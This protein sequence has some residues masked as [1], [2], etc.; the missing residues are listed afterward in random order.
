MRLFM[1]LKKNYEQR[2]F[3]L[4]SPNYLVLKML[5]LRMS[6]ST[7]STLIAHLDLYG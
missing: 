6:A 4:F 2:V 5:I 1:Y 7:S 3:S